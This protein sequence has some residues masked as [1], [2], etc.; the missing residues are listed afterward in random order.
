MLLRKVTLLTEKTYVR[1][2]DG[3]V[4]QV[5]GTPTRQNNKICIY[6]R[7]I[8]CEGTMGLEFHPTDLI[9]IAIL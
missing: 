3:I 2:P 1:L 7:R 5:V 8:T 4:T 9:E 6:F